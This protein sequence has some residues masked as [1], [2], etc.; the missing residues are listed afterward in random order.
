MKRSLFLVLACWS[1]LS[2]GEGLPPGALVNVR[3]GL[4]ALD[5]GARGACDNY[6]T[7]IALRETQ[8]RDNSELSASGSGVSGAA[9]VGQQAGQGKRSEPVGRTVVSG[10]MAS[11]RESV[12]KLKVG[13][14]VRRGLGWAVLSVL[15]CLAVS[16]F[17]LMR[18]YWKDVH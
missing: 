4:K 18:A 16:T 17:L 6:L 9:L 15:G 11:G 2:F 3:G 8:I 7:Q 10:S 5:C 1:A 13:Q 14:E 12:G